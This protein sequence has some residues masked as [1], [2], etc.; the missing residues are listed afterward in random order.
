MTLKE[1]A[2]Q[3]F[4]SELRFLTT[5]LLGISYLIGINCAAFGYFGVFRHLKLY[6][7]I[8]LTVIAFALGKNLSMKGSIN[9]LYY[10][11]EPLYEEVR[12]HQTVSDV[13][14]KGARGVRDIE[15]A[16]QELSDGRVP[17]TKRKDLSNA[18]KRKIM[19]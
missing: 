13:T 18:D 7:G 19:Q 8:P 9:R 1:K 3:N 2:D 14:P 6:V 12:R 4:V 17:L 15:K 5:R 10:P 11:I 16:S